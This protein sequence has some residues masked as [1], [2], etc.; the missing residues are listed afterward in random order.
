MLPVWILHSLLARGSAI[1][2]RHGNNTAISFCYTLRSESNRERVR[3]KQQGRDKSRQS[4]EGKD[5]D[6][7]G[8]KRER[9]RES[10]KGIQDVFTGVVTSYLGKEFGRQCRGRHTN[11]FYLAHSMSAWGTVID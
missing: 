2:P 1:I 3:D 5:E 6:R 10:T 11:H 8:G 4:I 7:T 9:Q